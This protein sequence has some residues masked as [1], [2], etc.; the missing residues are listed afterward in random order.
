MG[1]ARIRTSFGHEHTI[2]TETVP[3]PITMNTDWGQFQ[4]EIP[5]IMLLSKRRST[6]S[7]PKTSGQQLFFDFID[8][9]RRRAVDLSGDGT[10]PARFEHGFTALKVARKRV[11]PE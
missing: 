9:F 2:T 11:G 10:R 3:F 8:S 5:F 4:F 7:G 6:I 1:Q